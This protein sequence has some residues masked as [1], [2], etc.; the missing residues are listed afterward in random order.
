MSPPAHEKEGA[1]SKDDYHFLGYDYRECGRDLPTFQRYVL[2]LQIRLHHF[3]FEYE[4]STF[5]RN[6]VKFLPP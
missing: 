6:I 4:L 3:Q 5:L 2:H 1:A